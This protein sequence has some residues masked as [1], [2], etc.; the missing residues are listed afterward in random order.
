MESYCDS[1]DSS[2]GHIDADS[3][4][5]SATTDRNGLAADVVYSELA[6]NPAERKDRGR[7]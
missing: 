5:E 6:T 4:E 1:P 7:D 3:S 2:Q